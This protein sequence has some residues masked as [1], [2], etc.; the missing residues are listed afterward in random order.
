[1]AYYPTQRKG[2]SPHSPIVCIPGD[3]W[4][5]TQFQRTSYKN[6]AL[7]LSLPLNRVVIAR[8]KDKQLVYYWFVQRGRNIANEYWSK[9]HLFVDA[10]TK[11]RTDGALV[12]LVTPMYPTES[13]GAADE[14]LQSLLEELEPR[15][16]AY[17]PRDGDQGVKAAVHQDLRQRS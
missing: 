9:W 8:G 1:V 10:I 17:L 12:R 7:G 4:Q 11:N 13:E 15:L 16:H 14:R 3:G 5:I 2:T 6:N